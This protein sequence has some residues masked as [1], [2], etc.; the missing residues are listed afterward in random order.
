MPLFHFNIGDLHGDL[1]AGEGN[2]GTLSKE[3]CHFK[4]FKIKEKDHGT[5]ECGLNHLLMADPSSCV[6]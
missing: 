5:Y 3:T 1:G 4:L 2:Q 6:S